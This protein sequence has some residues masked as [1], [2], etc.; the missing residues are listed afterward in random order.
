MNCFENKLPF[1]TSILQSAGAMSKGWKIYWVL[2]ATTVMNYLTM[3]LW[4]LP[5]VSKMAGGGVPF[6]MRLGGYTFD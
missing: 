6:D 5:M 2:V 1:F 3:V 4:S